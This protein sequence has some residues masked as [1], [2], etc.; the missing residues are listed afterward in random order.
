MTC[1][2]CGKAIEKDRAVGLAETCARLGFSRRNG[3][4]LIAEGRFPIP[5][6][7]AI[8]GQSKPRHRYSEKLIDEYLRNAPV[9]SV[10]PRTRRAS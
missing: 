10:L 2:H 8:V 9:A 6:V 5:S 7:P 4:R 3:E 1:P